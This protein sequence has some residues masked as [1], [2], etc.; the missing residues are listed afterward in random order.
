MSRLKLES[1]DNNAYGHVVLFEHPDCRGISSFFFAGFGD[2]PAT[3]NAEDI[4]SQSG[5]IDDFES[6][7]VP[8]GYS[9][10]LFAGDGFTGTSETISGKVTGDASGLMACQP[11]S[12]VANDV[13]SIKVR[14][15]SAAPPVGKAIGYWT[16]SNS[17]SDGFSM[18]FSKGM[19]YTN[20]QMDS[21]SV[22]DTFSQAFAVG[23]EYMGLSAS[24]TISSGYTTME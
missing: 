19:D 2:S 22:E 16:S 15:D 3:Y 23:Y 13:E 6:V 9:V 1:F 5:V 21:S 7:M 12:K 20:S 4:R 11:I 17:H 24:E 8:V 14:V 10:E 18:T